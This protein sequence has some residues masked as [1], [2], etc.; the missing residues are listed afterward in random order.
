MKHIIRVFLEDNIFLITEINGDVNEIVKHY[1]Q[2]NYLLWLTGN[3]NRQIKKIEFID[4]SLLKESKYKYLF[5]D[6]D[7][8]GLLQ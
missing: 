7:S 4:S 2:N 5:I 3:A 8:N 1:Q 6:L